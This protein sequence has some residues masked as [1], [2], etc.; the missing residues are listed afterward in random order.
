MA[1]KQSLVCHKF[2]FSIT[3]VRPNNY[4]IGITG[5]KNVLLYKAFQKGIQ[6]CYTFMF[7]LD[8]RDAI[9]SGS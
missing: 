1:N 3:G 4:C 6:P 7:G 2:C 5:D 8:N 9:L